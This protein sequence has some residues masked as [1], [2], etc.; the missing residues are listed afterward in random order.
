[1]GGGGRDRPEA[2]RLLGNAAL[3]SSHTSLCG[4]WRGLSPTISQH[5]TPTDHQNE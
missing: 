1:V 5:V 4:R 3:D 2:A